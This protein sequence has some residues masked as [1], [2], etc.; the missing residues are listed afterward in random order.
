[1]RWRKVLSKAALVVLAAAGLG[2]VPAGAFEINAAGDFVFDI[3]DADD[4]REVAR[5]SG[6]ELKSDLPPRIGRV[7]C[8]RWARRFGIDDFAAVV[9]GRAPGKPNRVWVCT[10]DA[11]SRELSE[12]YCRQIAMTY[13]GHDGPVV[14]CRFKEQA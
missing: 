13:V 10:G 4:M 9:S 12:A 7:E 8:A 2:G 11:D 14:T 6:I 5:L 3:R 1:M